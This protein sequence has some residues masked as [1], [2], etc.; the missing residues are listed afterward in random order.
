MALGGP[1]RAWVA[2][3]SATASTG[4]TRIQW[5]MPWRC[6][7]AKS[8]P[9]NSMSPRRTSDLTIPWTNPRLTNRL[10]IEPS[11]TGRPKGRAGNSCGIPASPARRTATRAK[12]GAKLASPARFA[13]GAR[14]GPAPLPARPAPS[15]LATTW[16]NRFSIKPCGSYAGPMQDLWGGLPGQREVFLAPES[17][18]EPAARGGVGDVHVAGQGGDHGVAAGGEVGRHTG[19]GGWEGGED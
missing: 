10:P 2:K 8:M 7:G 9:G 4:A 16:L 18:I 12:K 11:P 19:L 15:P 13:Q 1:S 6:S 5:L 14:T 3:L 17:G